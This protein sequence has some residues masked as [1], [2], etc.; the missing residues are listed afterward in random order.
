[1]I[2]L[3]GQTLKNYHIFMEYLCNELEDC[4][5]TVQ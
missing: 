4:F 5:V 2:F 1:M 3:T